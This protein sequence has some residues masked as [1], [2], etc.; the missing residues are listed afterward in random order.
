MGV[1]PR[2]AGT[3]SSGYRPY[4]PRSGG[5]L[6]AP[7][8]SISTEAEEA[9]SGYRFGQTAHGASPLLNRTAPAGTA[10]RG[11]VEGS[12]PVGAAGRRQPGGVQPERRR[13][14]D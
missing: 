3:P 6:S 12:P 11:S 8:R 4:P 14:W 2:P 13:E 7:G 1:A 5:L 9:H 10:I